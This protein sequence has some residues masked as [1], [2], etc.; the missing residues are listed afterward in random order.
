MIGA[1]VKLALD[2]RHGASDGQAAGG[3]VKVLLA[4]VVISGAATLVGFMV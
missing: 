3:I 2:H 1:G 4:V